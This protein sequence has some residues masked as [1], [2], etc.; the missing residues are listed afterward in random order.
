MTLRTLIKDYI[1]WYKQQAPKYG[2]FASL[3]YC[4]FNAMYFKRDGTYRLRS[5]GRPN[6]D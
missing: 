2:R 6:E 3:W 5:D 4:A 1:W